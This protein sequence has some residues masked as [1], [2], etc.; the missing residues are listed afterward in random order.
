MACTPLPLIRHAPLFFK[1]LKEGHR[2]SAQVT[3]LFK[4]NSLMIQ[5]GFDVFHGI[6]FLIQIKNRFQATNA[7]AR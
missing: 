4:I 7:I 1:H 3:G 5:V 6:G 2:I